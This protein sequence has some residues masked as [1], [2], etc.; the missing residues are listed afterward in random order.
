MLD[1]PLLQGFQGC[2]TSGCSSQCVPRVLSIERVDSLKAQRHGDLPDMVQVMGSIS[3]SVY[4]SLSLSVGIESV[5]GIDE[6]AWAVSEP[7]RLLCL[8]RRESSRGALEQA[9]QRLRSGA[10]KVSTW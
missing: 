6:F 2:A 8:D 7:L 4:Y 3:Q 9:E 5:L 1:A 10:T